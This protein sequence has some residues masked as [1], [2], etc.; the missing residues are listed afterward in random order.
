VL[1][2]NGTNSIAEEWFF[3]AEVDKEVLYEM[4]LLSPSSYACNRN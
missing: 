1:E 2:Q 4:H 3:V